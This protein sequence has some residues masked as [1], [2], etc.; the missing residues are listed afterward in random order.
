[1]IERAYTVHE[2]DALRAAVEH[3]WLFGTYNS[4]G[5]GAFAGRSFREDQ[6]AA[7]VEAIVRTHMLA[8]HTAADLYASEKVEP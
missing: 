2:L 1:V 7:S 8:G 6:K 3:K 5:R 4:P